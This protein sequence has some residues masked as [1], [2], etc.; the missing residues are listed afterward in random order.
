MSAFDE[1]TGFLGLYDAAR[2]ASRGKRL[3]VE[4]QRFLLDV[5]PECLRLEA[6][7]RTGRWRP[8]PYRVFWIR[9]PKPR[10]ICAAPFRDRVVHQAVSQVLEPLVESALGPCT[11]A[12]RPGLGTAA[13]L[14]A[15]KRLAL[16]AEWFLKLDV[17]HYFEVIPHRR[18]LAQM[19]TLVS[20]Q[21][22]VALLSQIVAH[23]APGSA[24][25]EGLPIGNLTSQHL[26]NL[27]LAPFDTA[28]ANDP[29][30]HG[31]IR[32]M[33]DM[34]IFGSRD[35]LGALEARAVR[36]LEHELRLPVKHAA[37][38]RGPV[39]SGVPFLGFRVFPG[40][41]R[42]DAARARRFR[43]M[44]RGL[45]RALAR[46]Q[47]TPEHAQAATLSLVAWARN[48]DTTRLRT[49]VI[50]KKPGTEPSAMASDAVGS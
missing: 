50:N 7:L 47:L 26:A 15:A 32:Y 17:R 41:V 13:A 23:G 8:G 25:G 35:G 5:E 4:A 12:C 20:D 34:L 43:R 10:R 22:L 33:D 3:S 18:L 28:M 1:A 11:Y 29:A 19:A 44:I 30:S 2:R 45:R 36:V 39:G 27:Y 31:A 21:R 9:D 6:E 24:S 40:L 14:V 37:T 49:S 38:R 48:G 42:F 46:G 16:E